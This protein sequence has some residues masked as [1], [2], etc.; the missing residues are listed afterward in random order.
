MVSNSSIIESIYHLRLSI[1]AVPSDG[2]Q[3]NDLSTKYEGSQSLHRVR[4]SLCQKGIELT[5]EKS[6]VRGRVLLVQEHQPLPSEQCLHVSA[7]T[8]LQEPLRS[9]FSVGGRPIERVSIRH[10]LPDG[11]FGGSLS[12]RELAFGSLLVRDC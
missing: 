6:R 9:V 12:K 3:D 2:Y 8:A 1:R 5:D 4:C 11:S 7:H 10:I